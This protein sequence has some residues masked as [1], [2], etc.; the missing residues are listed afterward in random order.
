MIWVF[1]YDIKNLSHFK[2]CSDIIC[3]FTTLHF[4][5]SVNS[6][7]AVSDQKI[8]KFF[9]P[10]V[11]EFMAGYVDA[12]GVLK[13][14][15]GNYKRSHGGTRWKLEAK[16]ACFSFPGGLKTS[17]NPWEGKNLVIPNQ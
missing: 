16:R 1:F 3:I 7:S 9:V 17:A 13:V 6:S 12:N 10:H 4:S 2:E 5:S 14:R 8:S 11:E 15:E